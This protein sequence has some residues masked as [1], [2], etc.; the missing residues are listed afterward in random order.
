MLR[1]REN[2]RWGGSGEKRGG[3]LMLETGKRKRKRERERE[4]ERERQREKERK[5]ICRCLFV[6]KM[7]GGVVRGEKN[8]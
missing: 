4:K 3:A 1:C 8:I 5:S 7:D 6:E 2:G